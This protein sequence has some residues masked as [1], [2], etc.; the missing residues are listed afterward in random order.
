MLRSKT[1]FES[2]EGCDVLCS[3]PGRKESANHPADIKDL[4]IRYMDLGSASSWLGETGCAVYAILA[5]TVVPKTPIK[6]YSG[7]NLGHF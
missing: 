2:G 6:C 7:H 4:T 5:K 3:F 1:L